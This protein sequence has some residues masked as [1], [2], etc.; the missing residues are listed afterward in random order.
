MGCGSSEVSLIAP[1]K[2]RCSQFLFVPLKMHE[3]FIVSA[4]RSA[5]DGVTAR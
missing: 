2:G 4:M 3:A 1:A 5:L